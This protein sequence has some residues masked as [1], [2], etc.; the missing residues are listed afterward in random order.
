MKEDAIQQN[1]VRWFN[2]NYCLEHYALRSLILHI[3]NQKQFRLINIGVYPGA[4]DLLV[5]HKGKTFFV[6]V[7][8]KD[9]SQSLAQVKFQSHAEAA[10]ADY[11]IVRSL[12]E[13]K[14]LIMSM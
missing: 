12:D 5:I 9:G 6:E 13:F 14:L 7:K 11:Y 10:G 4:A 3:P 2:N 8:T 1:I